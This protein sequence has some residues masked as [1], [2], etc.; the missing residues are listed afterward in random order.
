MPIAHVC[1][2]CGE[3]RRLLCR[4]GT[5]AA[6]AWSMMQHWIT[7]D[8]AGSCWI[9]LDQGIPVGAVDHTAK[10]YATG[11]RVKR[12]DMSTEIGVEHER[13]EI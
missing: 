4:A 12:Y 3:Q 10:T 1:S 8:H 9:M 7:L 2:I 5:N 13:Y 6:V 11:S